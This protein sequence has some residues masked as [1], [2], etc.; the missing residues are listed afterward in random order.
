M[1]QIFKLSIKEFLLVIAGSIIGCLFLIGCILILSD[2]SIYLNAHYKIKESAFK[3]D[4]ALNIITELCDTHTTQVEKAKCV[5]NFYHKHYNY[6][7]HDDGLIRNTAQFL[8]EGGVCRDFS[9]N[10]CAALNDLNIKCEYIHTEDHVF[11]I[12]YFNETEYYIYC[13]FDNNWFCH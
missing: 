3:G 2:G 5:V 10:V 9:V 11:P 8:N 13:I 6:S 12:I 4:T 7:Q 1:F